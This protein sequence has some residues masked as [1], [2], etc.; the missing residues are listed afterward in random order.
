MSRLILLGAGTAGSAD[1][2]PAGLL[3]EYGQVR[4]GFDGG[5]GS[6]PPENVHAW[7]V[8]DPFD[9]LQPRRRALAHTTG[10]PEPVVSPYDHGALRIAPLPLAGHAYGYRI[11]TGTRTAVWAPHAGAFPAWAESADL[12]FAPERLAPPALEAGVRRLVLTAEEG[13]D[14]HRARVEWAE[15]GRIYRL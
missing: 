4:I 12:M 14:G 13:R 5:P 10:M 6:E 7:L 2:A 3:L 15:E 11:T 1:H 9:P 8:S